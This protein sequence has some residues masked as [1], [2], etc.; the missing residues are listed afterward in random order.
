VSHSLAGE[1]AGLGYWSIAISWL[2]VNSLQ[3]INAIFHLEVCAEAFR[4]TL[5]S[6]LLRLLLHSASFFHEFPSSQSFGAKL[7]SE[8]GSNYHQ[9]ACNLD[10]Q[11]N[12]G[13]TYGGNVLSVLDNLGSVFVSERPALQ[14][15][16]LH[17]DLS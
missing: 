3:P 12:K 13:S 11:V 5:F 7:C 17:D 4:T 16:Y 8:N 10:K 14:A 6:S 1:F 15:N 9:R 2:I